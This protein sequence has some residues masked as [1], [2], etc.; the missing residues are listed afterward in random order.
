MADGIK[1]SRRQ[2]DKEAAS[3]SQKMAS[4]GGSLSN[5]VT[6]GRVGLLRGCVSAPRDSGGE[7]KGVKN[8]GTGCLAQHRYI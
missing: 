6:V 2:V 1:G 4:E 5:L 7:R 3:S 8:S